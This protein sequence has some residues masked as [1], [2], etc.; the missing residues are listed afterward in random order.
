V[1]SNAGTVSNGS[2]GR[3]AVR[4]L[5]SQLVRHSF[6]VIEE[7]EARRIAESLLADSDGITDVAENRIG[8]T[9]FWNSEAYIETNDEMQGIIGNAPIIID[10]EDGSVVPSGT[11]ESVDFY[12]DQYLDR[13]A[14]RKTAP[15]SDLI[16]SDALDHMRIGRVGLPGMTDWEFDRLAAMHPEAA[17]AEIQA[18][19]RHATA[20]GER[21][22]ELTCTLH[23]RSAVLETL[24]EEFPTVWSS[25]WP[26]LYF[27]AWL[28]A[29]LLADPSERT[30][31]F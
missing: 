17:A 29:L 4:Q 1:S 12:I 20:V 6:L 21:A 16:V 31:L 19:Q 27:F 26:R 8:W 18:A 15:K 30:H 9:Y 25:V 7:A 14:W 11:G 22:V 3:L 28:D 24:E 13:E 2:C 5:A 10:R 23:D